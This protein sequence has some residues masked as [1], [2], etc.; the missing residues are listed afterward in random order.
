MTKYKQLHVACPSCPSSDAY[1]E[2]EDGHG[3]CFACSSYFNNNKKMD[4]IEY[5]YEYLPWRGITK[6]TMEHYEC[7]TKIAPNGEPVAISF[8]YPNGAMK[9][10][11]LNAKE[12]R[13]K[14]DTGQDPGKA[15]LFGRNRF[16]AG[17]HKYVT[18]TEGEIDALSLYQV[19]KS[20]VLS[21]RSAASSVGDCTVDRA[22]LNSFDRIYLAFDNDAAGKEATRAVAKLFNYDKIYHV[23]F[24]NRKDANEYLAAGEVDDLRNIW[25]NSKKYQPDTIISSFQAFEEILSTSPKYGVP[26]PFPSLNAMTYG[27]RTG[28]T[29]LLTA[30]EKVGKTELMHHIEYQLLKETNDNVGAIFLEEPRQRHLQALAGIHLGRPVHLP[31][32]GVPASEIISAAKEAIKSDDRLHIYTHFGSDDPETI[33]D[34]VRFLTTSR[35]CRYILF[36]HISMAISGNLGKDNRLAIDYLSTKL[37][38]MVKELDF[39]LIMVSHVNDEGKTRDSRY[40]TKVA[41]ITINATRDLMSADPNVR[42]TVNISV[43]YNRYCGRTGPCCS[44]LYDQSTQKYTEVAAND[45]EETGSTQDRQSF[46]QKLAA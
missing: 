4:D 8:P 15:G 3:W 43:P 44:L 21:V 24:S 11:D 17:S 45:N 26:Y 35:A 10:R 37:E 19:L 34:T 2:Y 13:W 23:K 41:D 1:V 9:I 32:S 40:P 27:I 33:L 36:D 25:W 20:P 16:A 14:Y 46:S 7:L 31:D 22:Y 18:I 6:Q 42:N 30:Q 39:S 38:M 29:V 5:S 28:E 12:F